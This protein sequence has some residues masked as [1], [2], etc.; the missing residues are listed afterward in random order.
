MSWAHDSILAG[1]ADSRPADVPITGT[2]HPWVGLP[3]I[4]FDDE[5]IAV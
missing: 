1:L 3:A 5:L 4:D 2:L